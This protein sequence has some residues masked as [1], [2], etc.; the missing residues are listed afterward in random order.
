[1]V[2]IF[3]L[4]GPAIPDIVFLYLLIGLNVSKYPMRQVLWQVKH[5]NLWV[6]ISFQD[7][8]RCGCYFTELSCLL[9]PLGINSHMPLNQFHWTRYPLQKKTV[10]LQR[11]WCTLF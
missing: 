4:N 6:A 8:K 11:L 9:S 1:M 5:E 2:L 10:T 3:L 7:V